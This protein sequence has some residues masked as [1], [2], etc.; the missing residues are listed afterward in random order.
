MKKENLK[1]LLKNMCIGGLVGCLISLIFLCLSLQIL[2]SDFYYGIWGIAQE[3]DFD[4][5]SEIDKMQIKGINEFL[6]ENLSKEDIDELSPSYTQNMLI[7]GYA[8]E[9]FL[10]T[11]MH[12]LIF[13]AAGVL[14]GIIFYNI[15]G[16]EFEL[17]TSIK[18]IA[19]NY[20]LIGLFILTMVTIY[21]VVIEGATI[22]GLTDMYYPT[23]IFYTVTY[24]LVFVLNYINNKRLTKKLNNNL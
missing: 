16:K 9:V 7:L 8:I 20:I 18:K 5:L 22:Y 2:E 10:A 14:G 24:I 23:A 15:W 12:S 13:I 11:V 1:K 19:L 6:N 4:N 21:G 3:V 17:K